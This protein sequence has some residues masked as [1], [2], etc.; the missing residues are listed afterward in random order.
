MGWLRL[1][2]HYD[3]HPKI[4]EAGKDAAWLDLRGM[5][6]C[7]RH[8]TDG[9]IRPAQLTRI[10]SDFSPKKR[11]ALVERLVEVGRWVPAEDGGWVIHDFLQYN[12]S[13]E[14]RSQERERARDRM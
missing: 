2:D 7:A 5:L 14:A 13:S 8:E 9:F 6:F 10:G 3:D 4:V 1:D 11:L 12:P